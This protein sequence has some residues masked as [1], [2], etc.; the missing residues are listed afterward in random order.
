MRHVSASQYQ[1]LILSRAYSGET[2][3]RVTP[4]VVIEVLCF[5][6]LSLEEVVANEQS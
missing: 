6:Q 4:D 3:S 1:K 5:Q 2:G